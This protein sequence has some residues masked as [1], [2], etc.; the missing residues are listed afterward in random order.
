MAATP[1]RAPAATALQIRHRHNGLQH[2]HRARADSNIVPEL[3]T[4]EENG[5]S[6][7]DKS[8]DKRDDL[9]DGEFSGPDD[10]PPAKSSR[11]ANNEITDGPKLLDGWIVDG[12]SIII[13]HR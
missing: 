8:M 3:H 11:L 6:S 9:D 1:E 2:H 5:G 7:G 12:K 13:P 4:A 10:S